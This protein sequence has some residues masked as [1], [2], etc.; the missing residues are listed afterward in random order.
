M[1]S[2]YFFIACAVLLKALNTAWFLIYYCAVD[3]LQP[4]AEDPAISKPSLNC[5]VITLPK[6]SKIQVMG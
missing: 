4:W 2:Q 5:P 6:L 3:K 1:L